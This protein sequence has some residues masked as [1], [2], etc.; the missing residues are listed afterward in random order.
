MP[1]LCRSLESSGGRPSSACSTS[2]KKSRFS[3]FT[4]IIVL[5]RRDLATKSMLCGLLGQIRDRRIVAPPKRHSQILQESRR[6]RGVVP[7][8]IRAQR[9]WFVNLLNQVAYT[10]RVEAAVARGEGE[11]RLHLDRA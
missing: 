7:L 11:S 2:L 6:P 8:G 3:S 1:T 5:Q 4:N 9:V 10:R